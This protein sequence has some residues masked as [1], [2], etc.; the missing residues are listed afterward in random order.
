MFQQSD[1]SKVPAVALVDEA[2]VR[3]LWV[4]QTRLGRRVRYSGDILVNRQPV[5]APWL[6]VVGVVGNAKLST[7]DE[8]EVP[9]S[10]RACT[11]RSRREFGRTCSSHWRQGGVDA[12]C[13]A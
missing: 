12:R 10:T 9:S 2:A 6:T 1:D 4:A 3:L 8:I 7:L 13:A 11:E 5:P